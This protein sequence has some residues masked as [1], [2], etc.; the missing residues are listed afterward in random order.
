M[1]QLGHFETTVRDSDGDVVGSVSVTIYRNGATID[2]AGQSGT[3]PLSVTVF[4][5]GKLSRDVSN[6]DTVFLNATTGTTYS[7][8][9]SDDTTVVLS[10]FAGTLSPDD[11][12][13]ITPTNNKPTLYEDHYGSGDTVSNPITSSATNG[14]AETYLER[15]HYNYLKSGTGITTELLPHVY[16]GRGSVGRWPDTVHERVR[17][18]IFFGG[19]RRG[20]QR[21]SIG[22]RPYLLRTRLSYDVGRHHADERDHAGTRAELYA[23][24]GRR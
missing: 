21:S 11:L 6:Q 23:D 24:V 22:R 8:Y 12:D 14:K 19:A 20:D 2:G 5:A 16:V 13:E 17:R 15:G 3:S 4:N 9:A 10:G 1:P 18:R 7:A